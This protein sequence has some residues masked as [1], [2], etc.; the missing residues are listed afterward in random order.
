MM[1]DA[2][3]RYKKQIVF[4]GLGVE[5]QARL[6]SSSVLIAGVGALGSTLAHLLVRAGVGRVR[7]VDRDRVELGN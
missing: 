1:S 4:H 7:L 2:N 5:G 3:D 6:R